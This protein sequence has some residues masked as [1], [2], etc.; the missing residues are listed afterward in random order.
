MIKIIHSSILCKWACLC[1]IY[2][3]CVWLFSWIFCYSQITMLLQLALSNGDGSLKQKALTV[4]TRIGGVR[5]WH[6]RLVSHETTDWEYIHFHLLTYTHN[7]TAKKKKKKKN[8]SL[9][10][11]KNNHFTI[12]PKIFADISCH[13]VGTKRG[14]VCMFHQKYV[15]QGHVQP[16]KKC[17]TF[18][19]MRDLAPLTP[20]LDLL[21]KRIRLHLLYS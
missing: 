14:N 19:P 18:R 10:W 6:M 16:P 11:S 4:L 21:I 7:T 20:S 12:S 3:C 9:P 8:V 13:L 2:V 15:T 17:V 5:T 1:F